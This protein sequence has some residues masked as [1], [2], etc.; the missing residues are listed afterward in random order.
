MISGILL[1]LMLILSR[2]AG[3]SGDEHFKVDQAESVFNY[4]KSHGKDHSAIDTENPMLKYYGQSFDNI[5][6]LIQKSFGIEDFYSLRHFLNSIAG[7]L[8]ILFA[9]LTA[10]LLF[11]WRAGVVALLFMFFSPRILGHSW[12]NPKDIPFATAFT[13]SIYFI[14]KFIKQLPKP[15]ITTVLSLVLGI[16]GSISIRIGGLLLIPYLFLFI[17]LHYI[18]QKDFYNKT[19]FLKAIKILLLLA[20]ICIA[21]YFIGL[22]LWPYGLQNPLKNPFD[23]LSAYTHYPISLNQLFEGKITLSKD[24]PWYY[25]F[26]YI[27]ITTPLVIFIGLSIFIGTLPFRKVPKN[28]YLFYFYLAFAFLFPILYTIYKNSNLYGGW[29]QLLFAYSPIV[30]LATGGFEY[31]LKR[32]HKYIKYGTLLLIAVLLINPVKHTIKNHPYEYIYYNQLVG[33][34]DGA[35]GKYEMDYYYH[36]LKGASDWFIQNEMT[37][38]SITIATNHAQIAE[39]YFRKYPNVHVIYTRY[40]EKSTVQWDYAIWANTGINPYQLERNLWPPK[41]ALHTINVDN[42]P[43]AA[44]VKRISDEDYQGFEALKKNKLT[45]AEEHFHAY[46]KLYPENEEVLA[47]IA[48]TLFQENKIED[49][50]AFADSSLHYDTR[51]LNAYAA[52]INSYNKLKQ[53]QDAL[54]SSNELLAIGK[55]LPQ[56]HF[57]K[58]VALKGLNQPNQALNEFRIAINLKKDFYKAYMRV[59]EILMNYKKYDEAISSVYLKILQFKKNDFQASIRIAKCYHFLKNN[60]K[61]AQIINQITNDD[62]Q[63]NFQLVKLKTRMALDHD[64]VQEAYK[65]LRMARTINNNSD[66]DV[67]RSLYMVKIHK[68]KLAREYVEK[69]LKED[70]NNR[71]AKDL[72]KRLQPKTNLRAK[73]SKMNQQSIM[74]QKKSQKKASVNPIKMP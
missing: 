7:W 59:G 42:T 29:R 64:N 41:E 36:S 48:S 14:L 55:S 56:A 40:Y 39:Y 46:L 66:M 74:F 20:V 60:Q 4:F 61:A 24:L 38:D 51:Q 21:G 27:L 12:N 69:A 62:N 8:L 2:D 49:A 10:T 28:N 50:I 35:Y 31:L 47:G 26:K 58:G 43:I 18:T 67:I 11:G 68:L 32:K 54:S 22:L 73:Q 30:I 15:S 63:Y 71:E 5:A 17:G 70:P 23:A 3:I 37:S 65:L 45:E 9:G 16:A 57:F 44:V 33:G 53:Y 13:F 52:K 34:V 1:I 19:S 72:K 6:Y 25:T